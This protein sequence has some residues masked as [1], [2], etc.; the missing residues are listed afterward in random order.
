MNARKL[1]RIG[2]AIFWT[3]V[4]LALLALVCKGEDYETQRKNEIEVLKEK[5]DSFHTAQSRLSCDEAETLS[6]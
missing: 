5:Y 6:K 1:S 3:L 2:Q 4:T